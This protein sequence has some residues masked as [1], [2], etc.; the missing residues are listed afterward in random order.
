[1][2]SK[3]KKCQLL[4]ELAMND[5]K[6]LKDTYLSKLCQRRGLEH[7][8]WICLISSKQDNYSPSKSSRMEMDPAWE[9]NPSKEAFVNMVKNVW[10]HVK[11]ERVMRL[12]AH[13]DLPEKN[14]DAMIGRVA[15][16]R[17]IE[18]QPIMR[19]LI[20]SYGFLFR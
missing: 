20:H 8:K 16:I 13:F 1:M 3:W 6:D 4:D 15:H 19:M 14:V 17:F 10:E 9:K 5:A 11:P 7:F 2:L 18:C 12:R